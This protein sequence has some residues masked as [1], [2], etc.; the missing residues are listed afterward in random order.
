[1]MSLVITHSL[2]LSTS[3]Q[4]EERA[5]LWSVRGDTSLVRVE[6]SQTPTIATS[7]VSYW[8]IQAIT[9]QG[10]NDNIRTGEIL[11]I[12]TVK[13]ISNTV[14]PSKTPK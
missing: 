1:M 14:S 9:V 8:E 2:M 4:T 10:D 11:E 5:A 7:A 3:E 6:T 12:V 13:C